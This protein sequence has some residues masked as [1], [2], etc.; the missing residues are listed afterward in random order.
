MS[1]PTTIV[2]SSGTSARTASSAAR[3][4]WM[5]YRAATGG[6]SRR[7]RAAIGVPRRPRRRGRSCAAP[8]RGGPGGRSPSRCHPRPRRAGGRACRPPPRSPR[9]ARRR[10]RRRAGGQARRRAL[11]RLLDAL[12]LEELRHRLGRQGTLGEP[13]AHLLLVEVDQRRVRL[14]VVAADDLDELAV[15]RRARI[16]G[17]DAVDRVLL[18]ADPRQPELHCHPVTFS[19]SSSVWTSTYALRSGAAALVPTAGLRGRCRGC[20]ESAASCPIRPSSSSSPSA[21]APRSAD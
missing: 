19:L 12:G 16:G 17:D 21:S 7:S 2:A 8:A 4:P 14:R 6:I 20:R 13:A 3:L 15:A 18:R 9:R 5:S 10:A 1:P 11:T